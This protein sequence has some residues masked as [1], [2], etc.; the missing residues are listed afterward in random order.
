MN[1]EFHIIMCLYRDEICVS[2]NIVDIRLT[3]EGEMKFLFPV[4]WAVVDLTGDL[5]QDIPIRLHYISQ[6]PCPG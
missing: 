6:V 4:N 5:A 3:T 1:L 2:L